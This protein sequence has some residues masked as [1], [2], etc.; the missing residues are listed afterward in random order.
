MNSEKI[1]RAYAYARERYASLGVDTEKALETLST[2]PV[3]LHCWQ[4]DDVHGFEISESAG[5]SNGILST[6]NYPGAARN[7]EELRRDIE[8]HSLSC[9]VRAA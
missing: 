2:I 4:G 1:E 8:K 9:R 3:S 5:A 7:A 6:G